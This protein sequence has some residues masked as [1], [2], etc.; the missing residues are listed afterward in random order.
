MNIYKELEASVVGQKLIK[1]GYAIM[2]TGGGCMCWARET[3]LETLILIGQADNELGEDGNEEKW[4]TCCSGKDG[5]YLSGLTLNGTLDECIAAMAMVDARVE[6]TQEWEIF[7][8]DLIIP[9]GA[10]GTVVG[11]YANDGTFAVKMDADFPALAEW[12]NE[13]HLNACD[14]AEINETTEAAWVLAYVAPVSAETL[15]GEKIDGHLEELTAEYA[16]WKKA[17]GLDLGSADE[18][19]FDDALTEE[20]RLWLCVFVE[21]WEQ[22]AP[23]YSPRNPGVSSA[24]LDEEEYETA[25]QAKEA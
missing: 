14:F 5:G 24:R 1:A 12:G 11:T 18:H 22:S 7:S 3:S 16:A 13:V 9:K 23:Y 17:N 21:R 25:E 10:T 19:L 6:F 2:N 8:S 15:R 20:Q 4:N